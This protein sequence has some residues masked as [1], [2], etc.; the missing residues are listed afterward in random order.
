MKK[1]L[2]YRPPAYANTKLLYP[3]IYYFIMIWTREGVQ[4]NGMNRFDVLNNSGDTTLQL[5]KFHRGT[6]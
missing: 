1:E 6:P 5:T 4:M 2:N 3:V